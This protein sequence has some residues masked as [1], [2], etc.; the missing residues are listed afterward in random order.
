MKAIVRTFA[1]L[2][3]FTTAGCGTFFD[4]DDLRR[5]DA[6]GRDFSAA[7][8]REYKVFALFERD[9]MWDLLDADRFR[10]K[11][12]RS[13]AS[14]TPAPESL[15]DWTLPH[16]T[17]A[18]LT[19]ARARLIKVLADGGGRF[20]PAPAARA[21]VKFDCWLEQQEEDMQPDH[22]RQCRDGFYAAMVTVERALAAA[23]DNAGD[24]A[25]VTKALAAAPAIIVREPSA[26]TL[27]FDFDSASLLPE[28]AEALDAIV[29]AAEDGETIRLVI[30]GHADR[31]GPEPYNMSLS[32]RRAASIEHAL[33]GRGLARDRITVVAYGERRPRVATP[34]GAREPLNRRVEIIVGAGPSL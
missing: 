32:R 12:L 21:Q 18:E 9:D 13:A 14:E 34:N 20:M 8:A 29:A 26:F 22:I 31:A 10:Q 6:K 17:L 15:D 19:A 28:H 25:K 24:G 16:R 1:V 33:V 5:T 30:G 7:L 2:A 3:A 23:G 11:A 27:F 4:Y